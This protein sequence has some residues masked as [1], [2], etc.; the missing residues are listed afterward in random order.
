MDVDTPPRPISVLDCTP[1]ES[2][3]PPAT[4]RAASSEPTI[5]VLSFDPASFSASEAFGLEA[6][7]STSPEIPHLLLTNSVSNGPR[8]R[9]AGTTG[10]GD[11]RASA[12]VNAS[13]EP[14][15]ED[16]YSTT[17]G[18]GDPGLPGGGMM[19]ERM[20]NGEF[21]FQVHHHH[22]QDSSLDTVHVP[23]EKWLDRNTPYVLLG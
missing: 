18:L 14:P 19:G 12:G 8:R 20:R 3:A 4:P 10:K 11:E 5:P 7:S 22:A 21:S 2:A 16:E 9:T 15:S 1:V 13:K 17:M 23:R 6:R